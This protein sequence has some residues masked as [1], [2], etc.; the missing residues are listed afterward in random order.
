MDNSDTN[1]MEEAYN[2]FIEGF[3]LFQRLF[4]YSSS[5]DEVLDLPYCLYNDLVLK[6]I[7]LKKKEGEA[8]EKEQP[9]TLPNTK[10]NRFR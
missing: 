5:I 3:L 9:K 6:Q 4:D 7:K 10:N 2:G 8:I 1:P